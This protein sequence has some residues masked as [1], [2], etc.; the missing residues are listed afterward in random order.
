MPI[1]VYIQPANNIEKGVLDLLSTDFVADLRAEVAKWWESL[2]LRKNREGNQETPVLGALLTDGPIRMITTGQ[3]LT[4]EY[5]EKTLH[6]MMFKDQQVHL[7]KNKCSMFYHVFN[8]QLV[9]ISMGA[10]RPQKRRE[11]GDTPSILPPPPR[12][13]LPTLLLLQPP[14]FEQLFQLMQSLSAM[15]TTVKGG[16]RISYFMLFPC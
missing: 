4:T 8:F 7:L 13:N 14:Y 2:Q 3:E 10:S 1:R 6:E 16:V 5:D 12:E 15:K 11:I 9:Y